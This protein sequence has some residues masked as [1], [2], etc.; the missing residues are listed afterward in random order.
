MKAKA[1]VLA[2]ALAAV[3]GCGSTTT[4]VIER[5]QPSPAVTRTVPGTAVTRTV[6][7]PAVTRTIT[8]GSGYS[9]P[10]YVDPGAQYPVLQ[11]AGTGPWTEI[12]CAVN[13]QDILPQALAEEDMT[14]SAS[15]Y[16]SETYLVTVANGG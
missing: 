5:P 14:I 4:T 6:P 1:A 10:C 9:L 3:A 8:A 16:G 15:G 7:G 13:I 11:P 2:L 12:T